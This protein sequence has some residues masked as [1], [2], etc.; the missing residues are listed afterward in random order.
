MKIKKLNEDISDILGS[1]LKMPNSDDILKSVKANK[2]PKRKS[3]FEEPKQFEEQNLDP[4]IKK[5]FQNMLM[6]GASYSY[7]KDYHTS[8]NLTKYTHFTSPIRRY[9]DLLLHRLL[10]AIINNDKKMVNYIISDIEA[11]CVSLS[12]LERESAKVEWDYKDRKFARWASNN[13]GKTFRAFI[14]DI[15]EN[16]DPIAVIDDEIFG[17]RVFIRE[18]NVELFQEIIVQILSPDIATTKVLGRKIGI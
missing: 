4:K 13:I 12:E 9:S 8:L 17:A 1:E 15:R 18:T 11:I 10:K 14:T 16:K 6:E 2:K 3:I 7:D 5:I